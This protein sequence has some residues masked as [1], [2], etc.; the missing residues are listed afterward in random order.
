[1]SPCFSHLV[2]EVLSFPHLKWLLPKRWYTW[3]A[4][5]VSQPAPTQGEMRAQSSFCT[6]T[7]SVPLNPCLW[8]LGLYSS[9]ELCI[10]RLLCIWFCFNPFDRIQIHNSF[11]NKLLS[12]VLI[13]ALVD[14]SGG[15][16]M[17]LW[18]PLFSRSCLL[19]TAFSLSETLT[20]VFT[21][22]P[23]IWS[24]PSSYTLFWEFFAGW[25]EMK[26][27]KQLYFPILQE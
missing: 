11:P 27:E 24:V 2:F 6:W 21:A 15:Y 9:S 17:T 13:C 22:T 7:I 3:A 1:M 4:E 25:R 26:D 14:I 16:G 20:K 19:G 5:W 10:S 23:L 12:P 18:S 8:V